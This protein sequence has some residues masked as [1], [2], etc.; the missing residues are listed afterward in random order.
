MKARLQSSTLYPIMFLLVDSTDHV[1]GKT[2][3]TPT[4][5]I[6]KNGA[7]FASPAGAVTELGSGW[8]AL[9]GNAT[10]RATLG[11]LIIHATG[12]GAD[13]V[14]DRYVIVAFNPFLATLGSGVVAA[15]V[16][17]AVGSVTAAVNVGTI[18]GADATDA[19]TA[20]AEAALTSTDTTVGTIA[21]DVTTLLGRLSSARA[22]YLD[23]LSAGAVALASGV[24]VTTAAAQKI[25]DTVLRRTTA[26]VEASSDGDTIGGRSL[27]GAVA[28]LVHKVS[29][30][31]GTMTVTKA[32]DTTALT[33]AV[34]TT[35][36]SADPVTTVDPAA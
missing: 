6:S 12:T 27:Y 1:T 15:S 25:A 7:A 19:I 28:R 17:G 31:A 18:E 32:D 14:D 10:D 30:S 36:A 2:G 5:T 4:V 22:G 34:L 24:A 26:N 13:P 35:D 20:A 29:T 3:L 33:T 11:D 8:Y 23:N 9:A 16:T 21:A